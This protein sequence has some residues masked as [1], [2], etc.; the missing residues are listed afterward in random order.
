MWNEKKW[1]CDYGNLLFLAILCYK[2]NV[3]N[4]FVAFS[5]Q[6]LLVCNCHIRIF[7]S[8]DRL[9]K[10]EYMNIKIFSQL[11]TASNQRDII[12]SQ[13]NFFAWWWVWL[14]VTRI[15]IFL[16]LVAHSKS[17]LFLTSQLFLWQHWL[18]WMW[19]VQL[20]FII[21]WTNALLCI[22]LSRFCY[23]CFISLRKMQ[24]IIVINVKYVKHL[25]I[26]T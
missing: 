21:L 4:N 13:N 6:S 3:M 7:K 8:I 23:L 26:F 24:C 12:F 11:N 17:T 9:I 2:M 18:G 20:I 1:N 14:H 19:V 5:P 25:H 10:I 22:S 16:C 15:I